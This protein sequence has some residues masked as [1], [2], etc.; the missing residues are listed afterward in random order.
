MA[1]PGRSDCGPNQESCCTSPLVSGGTFNRS[2]D[3]VTFL[4]AG[5]TAIVS[6]FR[7]DK[8]EITVG[9]FRA[10]VT[11]VVGGWRPGAGSGKHVHLN[12]G[13]GLAD[14]S[15]P[16]AFETGWDTG[17]NDNLKSTLADW[18]E[19]LTGI[20]HYT[21]G[22]WTFSAGANEKNPI[23]TITWYQ[24]YAFCIW[25]GGFL[26]TEAEWNYAA[27][28]GSEQRVFPWSEPPTSTTVDCEHA[29]YYGSVDPPVAPCTSSAAPWDVG[30]KSPTGDG[31]WGQSDLAGN[32][33]E[34]VLD[35]IATYVSPCAD[36]A[37]LSAALGPVTN[38]V[39]RGGTAED[40]TDRSMP[41]IFVAERRAGQPGLIW[42][43][44][45]AR[46][47]RSP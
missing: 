6:D 27:A 16:G 9:R 32:R 34:W 3:G 40:S 7:L 5:N 42:G 14:S 20:T 4:E 17:W 19:Q 24:A 8:Y 28:G 2:Y 46:C 26:P 10:F 30:F 45:G 23:T 11:A 41:T 18:D 31:R 35:W 36:C 44:N 47:A 15:A 37:F 21:N 29:N 1:G 33:G 22:T 38:R 13:K 39:Q 25:D 43:S 12:G